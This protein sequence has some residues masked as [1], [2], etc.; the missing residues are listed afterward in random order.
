[1]ILNFLFY[2]SISISY[3][4]GI[5]L[6]SYPYSF[7]TLPFIRISYTPP[8]VNINGLTRPMKQHCNKITCMVWFLL[9][10]YMKFQ[11]KEQTG[12]VIEKKALSAFLNWMSF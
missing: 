5:Q 9:I 1:M 10:N 7:P 11:I 6:L 2:M 3:L 8:V 4:A 12:S